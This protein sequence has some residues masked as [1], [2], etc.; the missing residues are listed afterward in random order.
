MPNSQYT[1]N[2]FQTIHNHQITKFSNRT[3]DLELRTL[4][5]S[6]RVIALCKV[7]PKTVTTLELTK[8]VVRSSTSIGANYREANESLGRKDFLYR[9]RITR[10]EAKETTYWLELLHESEADFELPIEALIQESRELRSIFT[11]IIDK[12]R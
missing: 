4:E 1:I 2:K 3:Y 8:Q 6:K 12:S 7:L 9:L 10:K 5:F 11:A